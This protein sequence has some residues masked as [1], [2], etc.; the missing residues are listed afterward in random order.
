MK[1]L[2]VGLGNHFRRDDAVGLVVAARLKLVELEKATVLAHEGDLTRLLELWQ[3]YDLVIL[4]DATF[5]HSS[6]GTIRRFEE[7]IQAR[8]YFTFSSHAFDL[9]QLLELARAIKRLP[10]R[11]ILYG[12]EGESYDYGEGLS[13]S[14]SSAATGVVRMIEDDLKKFSSPVLS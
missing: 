5:S 13:P 3:D 4:V 14:V 9:S 1:T 11:L 12:I 10:P 8:E 7:G 2:I 6:P